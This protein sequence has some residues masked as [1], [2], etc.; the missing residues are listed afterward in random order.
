MS[1]N[2]TSI[3]N[4]SNSDNDHYKAELARRRAEIEALL[5]E[6]KEKEWFECQA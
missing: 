3:A 5:Q 4:F 6:Q 2:T 1:F